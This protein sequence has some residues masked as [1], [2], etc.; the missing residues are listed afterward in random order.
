MKALVKSQDALSIWD[1]DQ[2]EVIRKQIAPGCPDEDLKFFALVCRKH[3]LD[4][5]IRQIHYV[6][7]K[8][9]QQNGSY[10]TKWTVQIGIDGLRSLA[11][12]TGQYAGSDDV[13]FD[14]DIG[15]PAK[16]TSTVYRITKGIR[17]PF[18]ATARWAEFYPGDQMGFMW[19]SK[20]FHMLGKTAEAQALRK[21]FP[22]LSGIYIEEELQKQD[23]KIVTHEES[24][25]FDEAMNLAKNCKPDELETVKLKL[26][27]ELGSLTQDEQ[28]EVMKVITDR[29]P[30]KRGRPAKEE[31]I[32]DAEVVEDS[33]EKIEMVKKIKACKTHEAL[34]KLKPEIAKT[35]NDLASGAEKDEVILAAKKKAES[36][37]AKIPDSLFPASNE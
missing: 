1:K 5:F 9:K 28:E 32:L 37:D 15:V 23:E 31:K 6:P 10:A 35:V 16:A 21:A 26:S 11:S 13:V 29:A 2:Q 3:D 18:V 19:K 25:T 30:K 33:P 22:E 24:M 12:R 8:V 36:F 17:C 4:P 20:P 27:S 7:R 34:N 14:K